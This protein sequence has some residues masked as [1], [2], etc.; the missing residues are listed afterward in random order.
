MQASLEEDPHRRA[1]VDHNES[2]LVMVCLDYK[3]IK[4]GERPYLVVRERC[5]GATCG[6]RCEQKGPSDKWVVKKV[7]EKMGDWGLGEVVLW[8]RSDGA[9]SIKL[10]QEAIRLERQQGTIVNNTPVRD[11]Q[12]NGVA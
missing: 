11:P 5:T 3:E 9:P 10:L 1:D 7:V 12:G 6:V 8:V 4:K 2:G